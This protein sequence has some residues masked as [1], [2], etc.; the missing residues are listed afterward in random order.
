M[1]LEKFRE[2]DFWLLDKFE[3]IGHG[4]QK[5][6]GIDCFDLARF[7]LILSGLSLFGLIFWNITK[8]GF[9]GTTIVLFLLFLI[10]NA[11]VFMDMHL[12]WHY[13]QLVYK[14]IH[15]G[16]TNPAKIIHIKSRILCLFLVPYSTLL[17]SI[18]SELDQGP[19]MVI[20]LMTVF[21]P[22]WFI[23]GLYFMAW[24]PLPPAPQLAPTPV[25]TN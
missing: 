2:F 25:R 12:V 9:S 13:E 7:C 5:T 22:F 18:V 23:F 11:L 14:H 1:L 4:F 20:K 19:N 15:Q 16:L 17:Y 6:V 10:V 21:I 24:D 3:K 8:Y